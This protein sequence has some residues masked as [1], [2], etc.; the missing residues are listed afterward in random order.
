MGLILIGIL[1]ALLLP[2][3]FRVAFSAMTP[4]LNPPSLVLLAALAALVYLALKPW[5]ER[6]P[7][8]AVPP[9]VFWGITFGL[10]AFGVLNIEIASAFAVRG[11]PFS[12]L[13]RGSLSMQLAYSIGWLIFAI[14]LLVVGI[15]WNSVR[16][17]WTAIA[18]IVV[19]AVKIF[20]RDL[21]SLGQL[22]RVG[23]LLGLAVVLILVSFL[24]QRFLSEGTKNET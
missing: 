15:N 3:R 10:A 11:S 13:T 2:F 21:W 12:M 14:G 17:R 4:L 16:V 18:A 22:Y 24:Y 6:W 7:L 8:I 20:I 9:R 1:N 5:D 19:T 23:S